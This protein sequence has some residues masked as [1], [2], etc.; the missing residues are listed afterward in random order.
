M[1]TL[2][3]Q[4]E[5]YLSPESG[6]FD[7]AAVTAQIK[8]LGHVWQHPG[9]PSIFL[10]FNNAP[11]L[12]ECDKAVRDHPAAPLPRVLL[13]DVAEDEININQFAGPDYAEYSR[14]FLTWLLQHYRCTAWNED[15]TD[16]TDEL[17]TP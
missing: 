6:S 17:P 14:A 9:A 10:I 4:E 5:I 16:L 15:G 7:V 11:S 1:D 12:E 3:A 2:L 13:I 8:T